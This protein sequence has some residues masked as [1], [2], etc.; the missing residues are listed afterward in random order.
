MKQKLFTIAVIAGLLVVQLSLLVPLG[1]LQL[2]RLWVLQAFTALLFAYWHAKHPLASIKLQPHFTVWNTTRY[3]ASADDRGAAF[4]IAL[5]LAEA[6]G[7]VLLFETRTNR[8]WLVH[9]SSL[10]D[11]SRGVSHY[12]IDVFRPQ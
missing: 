9:F 11:E 10:V 12:G 6:T 3:L 5:R 8:C 2:L 1:E 7:D 4:E